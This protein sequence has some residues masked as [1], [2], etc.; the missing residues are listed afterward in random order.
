MLFPNKEHFEIDDD[1]DRS[2]ISGILTIKINSNSPLCDNI[3]EGTT[4]DCDTDQNLFSYF[5]GSKLK[6][7]MFQWRVR[8]IFKEC[9]YKSRSDPEYETHYLV[10]FAPSNPDTKNNFNGEWPLQ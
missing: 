6:L 9:L 1:D 5:I 8:R 3:K 4:V 2:F 10:R 7:D